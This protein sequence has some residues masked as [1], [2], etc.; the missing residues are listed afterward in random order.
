MKFQRTLI[1]VIQIINKQNSTPFDDTDIT[2]ALELGTSLSIA[3]HN[4]YR[5]QVTTKIIR[6]RSRYNYLLDR[7]PSG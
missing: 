1:G 5:L 3:I 7:K 4:I 2:Y 6:Q